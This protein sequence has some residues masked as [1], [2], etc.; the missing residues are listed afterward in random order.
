[1]PDRALV[2]TA[3]GLFTALPI[4]PPAAGFVL[5]AGM[6]VAL[7]AAFRMR[8]PHA[9]HVGLFCA[10][11]VPVLAF[12]RGMPWPTPLLLA[13][14]LYAATVRLMPR[15]GS[16]AAWLRA[17]CVDASLVVLIVL[18]VL[19]SSLALVIWHVIARPDLS[20][21]YAQMPRFSPV[22]LAGTGLVF[23]LFNA[24]AEEA[25]WRGIFL[26]AL[27]GTRLYAWIAVL[28]QAA[29]FGTCHIQG[30]PRGLSGV[31]LA[32]IYG[33][34]LGYIRVRSGGMLAPWTAHVFADLT[35]FAILAALKA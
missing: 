27:L 20:D 21:L 31:V 30:F 13:L 17:G 32:G 11:A 22:L 25:V 6:L 16:A 33:L 3:L 29:S 34:M 8:A 1:M 18:T 12:G 5:Y 4:A 14:V 15:L 35:I 2:L 7:A 28:V 23:A 19:T 26:H 9:R 10:I 24:A